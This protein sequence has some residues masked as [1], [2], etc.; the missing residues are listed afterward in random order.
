VARAVRLSAVLAVLAGSTSVLATPADGVS[1]GSGPKSA[2][3]C[4]A[5]S[6]GHVTCM[7]WRRTDVKARK[8]NAVAPMVT[9]SG[10]SPADLKSAY[11]I[12]TN[13]GAGSTIAVVDAYNDPNA[14]ADLATYRSQYGLPA[15][16]TANGCFR[17]VSQTGS[18]TSLPAAN[19]GWAGEIALD[20]QMAS[21]V[22]PLCKIL[23]VEASSNSTTNL[24]IA[25]NYAASQPGVKAI[26]NSWGGPE[27][28]ADASATAQ[29]FVHPGIAITAS[30]GDDGFGTSWPASAASVIAVGGT[31]LK[32]ASTTRGWSETVW[33]GAGSGC[34]A[35]VAK[36][37]Y[38][39][40]SGCS[41]RSMADVSAIADPNTG[42]AVYDS[43]GSGGWAVFGGTSASA[44]IIAGM[45]AL[46]NNPAPSASTAYLA[47]NVAGLNDV[48]S[49]QNATSCSSYLCKAG[50]GYDGPTGMGTPNGL[51]A[52]GGGGSGGGT[53][54]NTFSVAVAPS[55]GTL[56][57]GTSSTAT[58]NTATTE[59]SAQSVALSASGAPA[60]VS[61][62]FSPS[63]VT[64]GGSSTMTIT[65]STSVTP[66][67]YTIA[68][69]G[70]GSSSSAS[71]TYGLTVNAP[72][73]GG[74]CTV[75][76][77]LSNTGFESGTAP[78]STTSGVIYRTSSAHSGSYEA[79]LDGYGYTHTDTASQTVSIPSGCTN[80]AVSFW[81]KTSTAETTTST[82]RDTL[83]V[84]LGSTT[85]ATFSNLTRYSN[86]TQVTLRTTVPAGTTS[87][88]LK[89]TGSEN[90]SRKTSFLVDDTALTVS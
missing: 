73:S 6:A 74:S 3:V 59:G 4:A 23:L 12:P 44:P 56:T 71:G 47:A 21:A 70:A 77:R 84:T 24:G 30:T 86:W 10:W 79:F 57:A 16:T 82:A 20:I 29:Y 38:Q 5:P 51:L 41:R 22:C 2:A 64:S 50:V 76:Q 40:D 53:T 32:K 85:L 63:T 87:T 78:W 39:L 36:P 62:S 11:S 35:Y 65:S 15:C 83:K 48:T 58:V 75:S 19:K 31:S 14:E 45:Y 81:L 46:A 8:A 28:T 34:S 18:T 80:V 7:S 43:Y 72:A 25:E 37:A 9:P 54:T 27:S 17:K 26:S 49:G 60:G 67:T 88:A 61:V 42:V 13:L 66:G 89:F 1:S 55:S 68:V 33:N 52:L 90:N 69:N